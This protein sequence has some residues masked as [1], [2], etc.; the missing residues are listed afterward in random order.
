MENSQDMLNKKNEDL[1]EE[2]ID[3][4]EDISVEIIQSEQKQQ[5]RKKRTSAYRTIT[6]DLTPFTGVLG[7][8]KECLR[9]YW[10]Q[11]HPKFGKGHKPKDKP[12]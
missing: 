3:K 8:K 5:N 4:P 9:K 7:E 12:Q 2:R 6:K 1:R 10:L 11:Q